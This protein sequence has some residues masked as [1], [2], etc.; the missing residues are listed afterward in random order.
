MFTNGLCSVHELLINIMYLFKQR[1]VPTVVNYISLGSAE[2]SKR[3]VRR[4]RVI[5]NNVYGRWSLWENPWPDWRSNR[6]RNTRCTEIRETRPLTSPT[7]QSARTVR[8]PPDSERGR[9]GTLTL[10]PVERVWSVPGS[11]IARKRE[12]KKKNTKH[13]YCY[14]R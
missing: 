13:Y 5:W 3:V 1:F 6:S 8:I 9:R 14:Y 10:S 12:K 11:W 4:F 7:R 2:F